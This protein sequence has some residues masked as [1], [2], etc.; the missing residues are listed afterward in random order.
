M[1]TERSR[2]S[3]PCLDTMPIWCLCA[4]PILLSCFQHKMEREEL[5]QVATYHV[6]SWQTKAKQQN[7]TLPQK[8]PTRYTTPHNL[9]AK[10]MGK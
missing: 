9:Q 7:K 5:C 1:C 8:P 6:Y 3:H 4:K 2:G 10:I